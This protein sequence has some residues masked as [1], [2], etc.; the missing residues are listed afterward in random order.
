[1]VITQHNIPG[2]KPT[3]P[4]VQQT[5]FLPGIL[6]CKGCLPFTWENRLVDGLYKWQAKIPNEKFRSGLACT[7]WTTPTK[8]HVTLMK[9]GVG[10]GTDENR[11]WQTHFS[12]GN[13]GYKF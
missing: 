3:C 12:F 7:I 1:M 8:K 4:T 11:K 9:I 13:S 6:C 2:R 5:G 10:L